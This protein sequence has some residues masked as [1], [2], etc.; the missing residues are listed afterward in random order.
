MQ[1]QCNK[2]HNLSCSA[3]IEF[4]CVSA[5]LH[6]EEKV[7]YNT[8]L[9]KREGNNTEKLFRRYGYYYLDTHLT[10]NGAHIETYKN[11]YKSLYLSE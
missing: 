10:T 6:P 7:P 3:Q 9:N 2:K 5:T 8:A 1:T 4:S 11:G